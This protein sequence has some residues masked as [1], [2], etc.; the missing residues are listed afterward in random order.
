M[1]STRVWVLP[2]GAAV[3]LAA[4][5]V[6]AWLVVPDRSDSSSSSAG[7]GHSLA[8]VLLDDAELTALL[9][10]P[11]T[12]SRGLPVSGGLAQMGEP[13]ASGDCVGVTNVAAR[14]MY[15]AADVRGYASRTW[16]DATPADAGANRPGGKV[17]FVEEAVVALPSAAA[18]QELFATFAQQWKRCDQQSVEPEAGNSLPGTDIH[19]T[20][21]RVTDTVLAAAIALDSRPQAPDTRAVGV[22]DNCLVEILIA[23]TGAPDGIGSSD[24]RTS[25]VDAVRAMMDKVAQLS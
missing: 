22:R 21:V 13:I 3:V 7:T 15:A 16:A 8:R 20:D 18:A 6:V 4:V 9:G 1:K 14:R 5:A 23:F 25:S 10:Q 17:M 11:F 19:I 2:A 24:P 12:A